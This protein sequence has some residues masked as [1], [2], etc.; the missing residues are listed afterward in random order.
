MN[1][2][3]CVFFFF[4]SF[5]LFLVIDFALFVN[6]LSLTGER[7][8][9]VRLKFVLCCKMLLYWVVLVL[10]LSNTFCFAFFG[11]VS[12]VPIDLGSACAEYRIF[13]LSLSKEVDVPLRAVEVLSANLSAGGAFVNNFRGNTAPHLFSLRNRSLDCDMFVTFALAQRIPGAADVDCTAL[14]PDFAITGRE[15]RGSWFC[16]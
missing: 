11:N 6:A 12:A 4:P 3:V 13:H 9:F 5:C 2:I 1:Y 8:S 15:F 14:S 7:R 10:L 16:L